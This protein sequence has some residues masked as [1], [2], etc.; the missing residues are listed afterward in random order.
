M[1]ILNKS[2]I[3]E[4]I[5]AGLLIVLYKMNPSVVD[6]NFAIFTT[7]LFVATIP[8]RKEEDNFLVKLLSLPS[9]IYFFVVVAMIFGFINSLS[10]ELVLTLCS[11]AGVKST[12][13]VV[14]AIASKKIG[15]QIESVEKK[16]EPK[17]EEPI[18][19]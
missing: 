3:R 13:T 12:K 16:E 10:I 2:L 14:Q 9:L 7:L 4:F 1:N 15:V 17:K 8:G 18:L 5:A 11:L 19:G 6:L